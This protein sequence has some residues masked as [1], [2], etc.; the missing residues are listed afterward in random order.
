MEGIA[1]RKANNEE[2]LEG[3]PSEGGHET[4]TSGRVS[5]D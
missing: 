5:G 4:K 2:E 1:Y 3:S